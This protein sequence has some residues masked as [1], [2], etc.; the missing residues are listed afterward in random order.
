MKYGE[1]MSSSDKK[2]KSVREK[3]FHEMGEYWINCV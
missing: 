3:I 1:M 2:K